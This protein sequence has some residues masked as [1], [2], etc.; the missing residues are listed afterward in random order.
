MNFSIHQASHAGNRKYNQDRVAYSYSSEALLMVLADGMGGHQHGE[1]AATMIIETFVRSF[2]QQAQARIADPGAFIQDTMSRAHE[3]IMQFPHDQEAGG[4]PGSTCVAA[5]I[6]DDTIYFGHAGDSRLYVLR[7]QAILSKTTDHSLVHQW[8]KWG[9]ISAEE[10]RTHP[11]R[12]QIIS[13]LGGTQETFHMEAGVAFTLRSGDVILLC[14]DGLWGPYTDEELSVAFASLPIE[15]TLDS[16]IVRAF[17][18]Q[19]GHSDNLTGVALRWGD[20]EAP[21][22]NVKTI[23]CILEIL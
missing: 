21:H 8:V 2:G 11:Q 5:L 20:G 12:N 14:S 1:L 19:D 17:E 23:N 15:Q 16:L 10:A 4:F 6:Q 7:D 18:S 13:C 9:I 22:P 3:R